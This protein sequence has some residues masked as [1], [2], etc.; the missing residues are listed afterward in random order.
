MET[1]RR[2]GAAI[3]SAVKVRSSCRPREPGANDRPLPQPHPT[4]RLGTVT[5]PLLDVAQMPADSPPTDLNSAGEVPGTLETPDR[6]AREAGHS[7]DLGDPDQLRRDVPRVQPSYMGRYLFIEVDWGQEV[8]DRSFAPPLSWLSLL[9]S[10]HADL[11]NTSRP[12]LNNPVAAEARGVGIRIVCSWPCR[13]AV[14]CLWRGRK[15]R[16]RGCLRRGRSGLV[17]PLARF[18]PSE[19]KPGR[20]AW[21]DEDGHGGSRHA[22]LPVVRSR[23]PP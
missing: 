21:Q 9:P 6:R 19:E 12:R 11:P 10:R 23:E 20:S 1:C 16:G 13:R 22:P 15:I 7:A 5:H 18:P 4:K 8:R 3:S 17:R 14:T 2:A